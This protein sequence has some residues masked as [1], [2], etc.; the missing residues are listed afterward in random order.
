MTFKQLSE[1]CH[2]TLGMRNVI[3]DSNGLHP[4]D[5]YIEIPC[6]TCFA[7][8][9]RKRL[10][11]SFRLI[12]EIKQ[13]KESSFVTLTFS[14]KY[15]AQFKD[16]PKRPLM[17][18]ID[19]LRKALGYRPRYWFISELGDDVKYS[20]RLHFHGIFFGTSQETLS[21]QLQRDKWI[22]GNSW[23]GYVNFKTA[24]YLTKYMLKFQTDYKPVMLLSNGIGLSYINRKIFDWHLNN[25]EPR[26]Y[27]SFAGYQYPLSNYYK[28]KLF[29][30]ELKT[31]F[32]INRFWSNDKQVFTLLGNKFYDERLYRRY[33]DIYFKETLKRG[34]SRPLKGKPK[35]VLFTTP[36]NYNLLIISNNLN[37][38]QKSMHFPK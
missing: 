25:F 12:Q 7:C 24:N 1:Y 33:R 9:K 32:A 14:D 15:L 28:T 11:W 18:Y 29:T 27:T 10:E 4:F 13:H 2:N 31:V 20:G 36:L 37:L 35:D 8:L 26:F 23:V 3:V 16:N 21:F 17:L 22:Y 30:D 6:G 38:C 19:R 34:T 5:E